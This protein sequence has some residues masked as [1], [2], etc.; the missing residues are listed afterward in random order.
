MNKLRISNILMAQ[1]R[2]WKDEFVTGNISMKTT[3]Q[4]ALRG[5]GNLKGLS[6]ALFAGYLVLTN[7]SGAYS[8]DSTV[9]TPVLDK[10][11]G[12]GTQVPGTSYVYPESGYTLT[13]VEP[14]DPENLAPNVI[15]YSDVNNITEG[16]HYYE[17]GLKQSEFGEG[18]SVKYYTW[19]KDDNGVKLVET[20]DSSKAVLTL[21]YDP[22]SSVSPII[23]QSGETLD[24]VDEIYVVQDIKYAVSVS[25]TANN[26]SSKFEGSSIGITNSDDYKYSA[27]VSEV[28]GNIK[29][30]TSSFIGNE[31][32]ADTT[33]SVYGTLVKALGGVDNLTS[34]FIANSVVTDS[35]RINGGL[36]QVG[37]SGSIGKITSDFIL[38]GVNS[39]NGNIEGAVLANSGAINAIDSSKFAGNYGISQGG[40]VYGAGIW[41][42]R[43]IDSITN[44]V[45]AGNSAKTGSGNARGGAIYTSSSL[46]I[47]NSV[48]TDNGAISETGEA[49]GGAV[50][51]TASL[52]ISANSG[53]TTEFSGNYIVNGSDRVNQAIWA[54]SDNVVLT[55]NA[56][57]SGRILMNDVIDGVEGYRVYLT[58]DGTGRISLYNAINNAEVY[59][60]SGANVDLADGNIFSYNFD[61]LETVEGAKYTID[62]DFA[63]GSSDTFTL[64]AGSSGVIYLD[65]LNILGDVPDTTKVIQVL[66]APDTISVG[67]TQDLIAKFH[68]ETASEEYVV[69]DKINATSNWS[70]VYLSHTMQD[71]T[72]EGIRTAITDSNRTTA[73]S[74]EY[75]VEK[76]TNEV[77]NVTQGDTLK[78]LAQNLTGTRKFNASSADETYTLTENTGKIT[79]G[80]LTIEGVRDSATGNKSTINAGNYSLV[81]VG[82]GASVRYSN[83][84]INGT[85]TNDGSVL[86]VDEGGTATLTAFVDIASSAENGIVND[87]TL[88]FEYNS[89]INSNTGIT[90]DGTLS[91][92]GIFN[93]TDGAGI[94]Q[95]TINLSSTGNI[96]GD[97]TANNLNIYGGTTTLGENS[98][99]TADILNLTGGTM[100]IG[101]ASNLHAEVNNKATLNLGSGTLTSN[102]AGGSLNIQGDVVNNAIISASIL[103]LQAGSQL[104]TNAD[105]LQSQVYWANN[106]GTLVLTGGTTS[107]QINAITNVT[108]D[109]T[110]GARAEG[111]WSVAEGGSITTAANNMVWANNMQNNGT[112]NITGGAL[113]FNHRDIQGGVV[114]I[115]GDV[116]NFASSIVADTLHVQEGASIQLNGSALQADTI[117]NDA[118]IRVTGGIIGQN[119][120]IKNPITGKGYFEF[121][122]GS[123][124]TNNVTIKQDMYVKDGAVLIANMGQCLGADVYVEEGGILQVQDNGSGTSAIAEG[125]NIT[126]DGQ[127]RSNGSNVTNNGYIDVAGGI[128]VT[129][130][131]FAT[132]ADNIASDVN[133]TGTIRFT[134]GTIDGYTVSGTGIT[135]IS[136]SV[137]SN[138]IIST[139]RLQVNSNST[140]T[141]DADNI[142]STNVE[143]RSGANLILGD[144]D[145]D[146]D[147]KGGTVSIAGNVN[148]TDKRV[149]SAVTVLEG[150]VLTA[151]ADLLRNDNNTNK[152]TNN[153]GLYLSGNLNKYIYGTGVTHIDKELT[154]TAAG[155]S[156]NKVIEGTLDLN[157]G[158]LITD[159]ANNTIRNFNINKATGTGDIIFNVNLAATTKAD[160]ITLSDAASD[161]IF[162]FN[163]DKLNFVSM[164]TPETET[165]YGVI[166]VL[167]GGTGAKLQLDGDGS[168]SVAVEK[169]REDEAKADVYFDENFSR[170]H[171]DGVVKG[172][173]E[174]ATTV[175]ENDSIRIYDVV[176][177]WDEE[178]ALSGNL[179]RAWNQ[180]STEDERFF[181]FKTAGDI[182]NVPADDMIESNSAAGDLGNTT[183]GV[184]NIVGAADSDNGT[185]ST[186]DMNYASGFNMTNANTT[187]NISDVTIQ[188][189]RDFI[190]KS[191]QATNSIGTVS[192]DGTVSGGLV[193]VSI[194]NNSASYTTTADTIAGIVYV[195]SGTISQIV[196]SEF[197]NN[198]N[199]LTNS[200]TQYSAPYLVGSALSLVNVDVGSTVANADGTYNG[201]I[202]NTVFENNKTIL[203]DASDVAMSSAVALRSGSVIANIKDSVFRNN[204]SVSTAGSARGALTL[205]SSTIHNIENTQFINNTAK[206]AKT[207]SHGGAI[208]AITNSVIGGIKNSLFDNNSVSLATGSEYTGGAI[209]ANGGSIGEIIGTTFSNNS[210]YTGGAIYTQGTKLGDIINSKFIGNT[211][212]YAGGAAYLY[213]YR[214]SNVNI[215]DSLFQDNKSTASGGALFLN[216]ISV[217][218]ITGTDFIGNTITNSSTANIYGGALYITNNSSVENIKDV[219]FEN[220]GINSTGTNNKYGGALFTDRPIGS[221]TDT[222][223]RG[224][225][226]I[227]PSGEAS[228]GAFDSTNSIGTMQNVTFENNYVEG[229][230]GATGAF[231]KSGSTIDDFSNI[232]FRNNH[233]KHSTN[234]GGGGMYISSVSI[235]NFSDVLFENNYAHS[236]TDNA[237][238]GAMYANNSNTF[239]NFEN[240]IFKNN[241]AKSDSARALGGALYIAGH[242]TAYVNFTNGIV[243]STFIGNYVD[244]KY[245]D[246]AQGGAIYLASWQSLDIVAKDGGE[247]L[248]KDNYKIVNGDE[249]TKVNQAIYLLDN[250]HL[251][252]DAN[253]GGTIFMYDRIDA[254]DLAGSNVNVY[255][256]GDE[257]GTI[258]LY[259]AIS[260]VDTRVTAD[261]VNID[262]ANNDAFDYSFARFT[263]EDSAKFTLDFDRTSGEAD[264]FTVGANS[265]GIIYVDD[266]NDYGESDV[267]KT[268]QIINAKDDSIQLE[269][270]SDNIHLETDIIENLGDT[271]YN[272][273]IYH[274]NEGY[275][276]ATTKTTNDSITYL[277]DRTY[278]GLDLI[279]KSTL[280]EIRNFNFNTNQTYT[281][282]TDLS[283]IAAGT[284]NINGLEGDTL[285][286]IDFDGHKAFTLAN[287]DTLNISNTKI[288]GAKDNLAIDMSTARTGAELNLDNTIID[289]DIKS[290]QFAN[291]NINGDTEFTGT[292]SGANVYL[293][294]GTLSMAQDTFQN[295]NGLDATAGRISLDNDTVENYVISNLQSSEDV[296]YS[297]DLDLASKTADTIKADSTSSKGTVTLDNVN[298]LN[299]YDGEGEFTVQVIDAHNSNLQLALDE[300]L[301]NYYIKDISRIEQDIVKETTDFS[302]VYYNRNRDGVL[303]GELSL[304]TTNT[305][306]DSV[307]F[308][309]V[310]NWENSTTQLDSLGDTLKVV[311]K[312]EDVRDKTFSSSKADEVY[313]VTDD[314]GQIAQG[315]FTIKGTVSG[316]DMST[317]NFRN[318]QALEVGENSEL[319]LSDIRLTG[320]ENVV[321][322]TDSTG[323]VN[324]DGAF[325]NGNI[326]GSD[327]SIIN[328]ETQDG[329]KSTTINGTVNNAQVILGSSDS[330]GGNFSFATDTFASADS[331]FVA[332]NGFISMDNDLIENYVIENLYSSD[333][334]Q[335]RYTIDIDLA[336][337]VSDTITVGSASSGIIV[338]ENM[339]FTGLLSDISED[340]EYTIK[341]LNAQNSNIKLQL[342]ET[343]QSALNQE[344][345]LGTDHVISAID[346]V[347]AHSMWSDVYNVTEQDYNIMGRL[348]LASQETES[349]SLHLYDIRRLEG[350]TKT[351]LGDTLKLVNQLETDENR[352][353][354]FESADNVYN[355]TNYLGSMSEGKFEVKGV[356]SLNP[357]GSLKT[358]TIN[359]DSNS[360]FIIDKA[361]SE[362]TISN[363]TFDNLNYRDGSLVNISSEDGI[364]NLNN[365]IVEFTNST[366]AVVNAGT[367]N[368]TGGDVI[369]NT[370]IAGT[371]VTNVTGADVTIGDGIQLSQDSLNVEK[372]SLTLGEL[373]VI[374]GDLTV[375]AEG[376][377]TTAT[378]GITSDVINDGDVNFTGGTLSHNISGEGSTNIQ[379]EVVNEAQISQN[380]DIQ[381]NGKLTTSADNV[382]GTINNDADLILN[383]N[384]KNVVTGSGK[385]TA[386]RS[387]TLANGAGFAG[388]LDMN[389]ASI[390][391]SDNVISNYNIGTMQNAGKFTIDMDLL[392]NTADKFIT[393]NAS[394]GTIYIDSINLL[395]VDSLSESTKIQVL[396]SNGSD[397]IQLALNSAISGQDFV[398]GRVSRDEQDTVNAVTSYDDSYHTYERGGDLYGSLTLGQTETIN[399]SIVVN[400]GETQW[401]E[402]RTETG[403]LGDTLALWNQLE[404]DQD[405]EFNFDEAATYTLTSDLGDTNGSNLSIN[406][407]SDGDNKSTVD[408]N[409]HSGFV[410][411]EASNVSLDNVKL[412]GSNGS[413]INV[414]NAGA[415]VTLSDTYVDGDISG[416][417]NYDVVI[418]GDDVT[419]LNGNLAN[420]NTSL[421][422]GSLKFNA[423][424]FKAETNKLT[425]NAGNINLNDNAMTTYNISE[426][427]SN[428]QVNYSID[429]NFAD[430]TSDKIAAG[431]GSKGTVTLSGLN[432]LGNIDADTID[433]NYKIQ[434]LDTPTS[435]LQLALSDALKDELAKTEYL[436]KTEFHSENAEIKA[437]NNWAD[438]YYQTDYTTYTYGKLGLATTATENDSI[439]INITRTESTPAQGDSMGDTLALVNQLQTEDNREF[440][441]DASS[442]VYNVSDNLGQTTDGSLSIN[443]VSSSDGTE[444]S[445]VDLNGYTGF[446]LT[447]DTEL[448]LNDIKFTGNDTL[449]SVSNSNSSVNIKDSYID[450]DITGTAYYN[451]TVNGDDT[452]TFNGTVSNAD[453]ILNGGGLKFNSDTFA[454]SDDRLTAN[455][456]S[457]Y[458]D[459]GNIT[460]YR[461]NE[462][463]SD[464]DVKYSIDVN[465]TDET[466]DTI[467]LT[468]NKSNGTILIDT[469]DFVNGETPSKEFTVQV[470]KNGSDAI[471]LALSD[472]LKNQSYQI[473]TDREDWNDLTSSIDFDEFFH[474]YSKDGITYGKLNTTTTSSVNDSISL[475]YNNTVWG[476]TSSV[477]RKDTLKELN[478][479][480]TDETKNFNFKS[481]TDNYTVK[482]NLGV[483][484]GDLNING[485]SGSETQKSTIDLNNHTGFELAND[486]TLNIT[487]TKLTGND[488]ALITVTNGNANI[489]LEDSYI[490]GNI[491]GSEQYNVQV[492]GD[493]VTTIK[494]QL[495]NAETTLTSGTLKIDTDTFADTSTTLDAQGGTISLNDSRIDNYVIN[496]LTSSND[497]TYSLDIN[498]SDKHADTITVNSGSGTITLDNLN[499]TGS[500]ANP[501]VEYKIQILDT[502]N[503]DIQLALSETLQGQLG[504]EDYL[505][506]TRNEITY[507]KLKEVTNWK[508][509]YNKY[510]QDFYTYG[511]LGLATTE[512]ENDSIGITV[513]GTGSSEIQNLGAMGDTLRVV[514]NS[515]ELSDKTFE[516]DTADDIYKVTENLGLTVGTVNVSGVSDGEKYSAID[517]NGHSGFETPKGSILNISNTEIKNAK[518]QQ[519][520]VIN[521]EDNGALIT[522]SNTKL[523]DNLSTGEHGAAIYS[524]SDVT[525]SSDNGNSVIKGNKTAKDD[526]AVYMAGS[527]K[528][529]LNAVNNGNT[530]IWD[531]ING[532]DGYKVVINGDKSGSVYLNNQIKNADV[533][534]NTVTLNLSGNNHFE[535]SNMTVNSGTLN[536]VNNQVQQQL[537]KS[538][539]VTG[540]FNLNADVDLNKEVMDRLPSNT[541]VIGHS[542]INV[543]KINLLSDTSKDSVAIPFADEQFKGNV[544]YIGA[545]ELSKD[546]QVTTAYAPIYKYSLKYEDRDD[547]GYFVFTK[548]AGASS[549][550]FDAY[551]PAVLASPVAAQ[552][553]GYAAMNETFNY[554]FKHSDLFSMLPRS[555]RMAVQ[556]GGQYAINAPAGLP[557]QSGVMQDRGIWVQPYANFESIGLDNGPDVDVTSYGTLV[558]GDG[559]YIRLRNGWGTVTT[560]YAGY[561]GSYQS[562]SGVSTTQN[563]GI[564]GATQTFYKNN[565]FTAITASAGA[566]V[567]DSSTM[568][569]NE[570]FAMLMAGISSKTGYNFEFKEGKYIIQPSMQMSYTFVNPFNYTN[571]AGV[572][573]DSDPLHTI[574]LRPNVKFAANLKHGW[575][576]YAS[577]GM[578]WNIMN[579]THFAA[580]NVVLPSM[581]IKPY[582]EYGLGVQK[583]WNDKCTGYLQAM[584][585][586][587]GRNGVALSTG[588]RWALGKEGKPIEKVQ[589][590]EM[591][592]TV[593][594]LSSSGTNINTSA[595]N[596]ERK[597]IKQS[598]LSEKTAEQGGR[599]IIKQLSF[600]QKMALTK[601]NYNRTTYT[602]A[603]GVVKP[604]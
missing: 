123:T 183:S 116:T 171:T 493:S 591:P 98:V 528:L 579:D 86:T 178:E 114:N 271:V 575:Q 190:I 595:Q 318:H 421:N 507:D 247:T 150:G 422:G 73:D 300:N 2:I 57:D 490:D 524:N 360:G 293:N 47:E 467:S 253:T 433:E 504:E 583:T 74:I 566:S 222:I 13:E 311:A 434:I 427:D 553:G 572:G 10:L 282:T 484:A 512:T 89:Q 536:L 257:T 43:N 461:I 588:F 363:I 378:N 570:S 30:I 319:N 249:S 95:D 124:T 340:D 280:N 97:I 415:S 491:S 80:S 554:A 165:D 299:D 510:S 486:T 11:N 83:I 159:V 545:S 3:Q 27:I 500:V 217:G 502:P 71:V 401:D 544:K 552:V 498:L 170:Y 130:G 193:N 391:T 58:G 522:L 371:G 334:G 505:I 296:R 442:N 526:E 110:L 568:Y 264:N 408:L 272:D 244:A 501:S 322:V 559:E 101:S 14:E 525:I 497:V 137:I 343:L 158:T 328:I 381:T 437:V 96:D 228:A 261:S 523:T 226:I 173:I 444:K 197:K 172:Q 557:V 368:M 287:T 188:N 364:A 191:T 25:G 333:T 307:K 26:I 416:T 263:S 511:K 68:K 324:L 600:E 19:A 288:T 556:Y 168:F 586:N 23:N 177:T 399:D 133:A 488:D 390:S 113:T 403:L 451:V 160:K 267:N 555:Q 61:R 149:Q 542:Y 521:G 560:A 60:Q 152:V 349:D 91:V 126:G 515:G 412:T 388:T 438:K 117:I 379:G 417:Q 496:D 590:I 326:Q 320:A 482:E 99:L 409:N 312:A 103:L 448:N 551:N 578:V 143:I 242:S 485:V 102:I 423:D 598:G 64:G 185:K 304:A 163:A 534:M 370:G 66:T 445:T 462:L 62:A 262:M 483:T 21:R 90:G 241:Y 314:I 424:T 290:Y 529:T 33:N 580:N 479:Y 112:I 323:V 305:A 455:S 233:A 358:S 470:I 354:E 142:G 310:E 180:M 382:S 414:T 393:G 517:M 146:F 345:Q 569:G 87:G 208:Y 22:D 195:Q 275:T 303:N 396:D 269:L 543:D 571:A 238:G 100:T 111:I 564:I 327:N 230:N 597:V 210:A 347:K 425:A 384:L 407:V 329:T 463:L 248:F 567:G 473:G 452:T 273:K 125:I 179:L 457:I 252:L 339:N 471:Q 297:L 41:N 518:A 50:Y 494:G 245:S 447:N 516:F 51:T 42:E 294:D 532:D 336:N 592:K 576:P 317:V 547:L 377:V 413:L 410:L 200:D 549:G 387:L 118:V 558:G 464:A 246:Y 456:G 353:F 295:S 283:T 454:S 348:N 565:F 194:V 8:A 94:V 313:T 292:I 392:S 67:L 239:G 460:D 213:N 37:S 495:I 476:E 153:G 302:D 46:N 603:Q 155:T 468:S 139:T 16:V 306:N 604:L 352:I 7:G 562:F 251:T 429:I 4:K 406:G 394:K 546:T 589:N 121:I 441:F 140:L 234:S 315:E 506:G 430:K 346:E 38:N 147:V 49:R 477:A 548:G 221:I 115:T 129:G 503:S 380:V 6:V 92:R 487:D 18:S 144:G 109:V 443:G 537:A 531:K 337:Q 81:E 31:V 375:G 330:T 52:N 243:N 48:F 357:D 481:S 39:V 224:N 135:E 520:A 289:G 65:N 182:Y 385:T 550:S 398:L 72:T 260:G 279:T 132:N 70:D 236:G 127:V 389:S 338:L 157:N 335:A 181:R 36:I 404:T 69:N 229:K 128:S 265:T 20:A 331:N 374:N 582:V 175:S 519:G 594:N 539:T 325:I 439:G 161:A 203:N 474:D 405:K 120:N 432:I 350:E 309:L 105:N 59:A 458:L 367:L 55:L 383:G 587:G 435:D 270:N 75:Y 514:N 215:K 207:S 533:S 54:G 278:D 332:Q 266:L 235:D 131:V 449:I 145:I 223:F 76:T 216:A 138:E 509:I 88:I 513:S 418:N 214:S 107:K 376:S 341:I 211:A 202:I 459:D 602:N 24:L 281:V 82:N 119:N 577:V 499:I 351:S 478:V 285:S 134:G 32:K 56:S 9:P 29:N 596:D 291:I 277:A 151:E 254:Q 276:L 508:D 219:L 189:A 187:L 472:E 174:L 258:K 93:L 475:T 298:F 465:L 584:I 419:T 274:Q 386:N 428:S 366:N 365:V 538:F 256:T 574:Q 199:E 154:M 440:N 141:I 356:S 540:N 599:K 530:H 355:L 167:F 84:N 321:T 535:T 450:G 218:D 45:F 573:I 255:L 489:N 35:A 581:S 108:G 53:K 359:M 308:D 225:Y 196:D 176:T 122:S 106:G 212:A 301:N 85:N 40:N 162:K 362:L 344:I 286:V 227:N 136:N 186:I 466:S 77:S 205:D 220:N 411:D 166:Q 492:S 316:D 561:N 204:S 63:K 17:V 240:V 601:R 373:S 593:M 209:Y 250:T 79:A 342:S 12:E 184:L 284:M 541:K 436:V 426:L 446:E 397:S 169:S 104:T 372:G 192:E 259:N 237:R 156:T 369:L 164:P 206:A 585:R 563:G 198:T 400:R 527:S 231:I 361:G 15:K 78:L 268:V 34:E 453:T 402:T 148:T 232:T 395:N 469:I 480:Q 44:T 201:G 431:E 5:G 420:A 1:D 28:N